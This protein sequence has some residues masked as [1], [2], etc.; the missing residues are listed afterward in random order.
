M[1]NSIYLFIY[2]FFVDKRYIFLFKKG[3]LLKEG[4]WFGYKKYIKITLHFLLTFITSSL[5]R[6]I[7]MQSILVFEHSYFIV[8]EIRVDISTKIFDLILFVIP[9]LSR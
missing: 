2:F 4:F 9:M 3:I 1:N 7:N 8:F 6:L 5:Y